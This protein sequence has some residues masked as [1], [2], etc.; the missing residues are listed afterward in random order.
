MT[1][2]KRLGGES[3]WLHLHIRPGNALQER[4]LADVGVSANEKRPGVGVDRR[5]TTQMLA[6]LV[7]VEQGI[8]QPL[9]DGGHATQS[10]P[11]QLLALEQRLGVLEK[12]DIVAGDR[13]D[14]VLCR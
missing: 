2:V 4:R 9:Q 3:I 1:N 10:S 6:N 7:K 8:L 5:Q 14:E 11:L 13:F 12:T